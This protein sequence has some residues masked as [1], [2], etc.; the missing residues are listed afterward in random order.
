MVR[1]REDIE[2][3][4][5][6]QKVEKMLLMR[7]KKSVVTLKDKIEQKYFKIWK[8]EDHF[9]KLGCLRKSL[10]DDLLWFCL[11]ERL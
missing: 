9:H 4:K 5:I 2:V 1:S 8:R 3:E 10:E 11:R 7:D 6:Q